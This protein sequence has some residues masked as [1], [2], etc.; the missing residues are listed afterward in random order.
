MAERTW[1]DGDVLAIAWYAVTGFVTVWDRLREYDDDLDREQIR[2]LLRQVGEQG[3]EAG[4]NTPPDLDTGGAIEADLDRLVEL[5]GA[6][7][8]AVAA[9]FTEPGALGERIWAT[10]RWPRV[11]LSLA[12]AERAGGDRV[13]LLHLGDLPR[14]SPDW[15]R[16]G[17]V[18]DFPNLRVLALGRSSL[19]PG[20]LGMDVR[21]LDRLESL[22]LS[23]N[24]YETIPREVLGCAA[25]RELYLDGN[26]LHDV[27]ALHDPA[28]LPQLTYLGVLRTDLTGPAVRRLERARPG[29]VVGH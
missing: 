2:S 12:T 3:Y 15:L 10:C 17:V 21:R 5:I 29:L 16:R 24:A 19:G 14:R 8:A 11:H 20:A 4:P 28:V 25:V 9:V 22:D 26:P 7:R 18:A 1:S 27:S 6:V 23:E 13:E